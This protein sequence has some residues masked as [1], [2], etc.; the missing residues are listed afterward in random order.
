MISQ[1]RRTTALC[2]IIGVSFYST[3]AVGGGSFIANYGQPTP[4]RP[5]LAT[6]GCLRA[7]RI[8][9]L[10]R[11]CPC[12]RL[13][14]REAKDLPEL[15]NARRCSHRPVGESRRGLSALRMGNPQSRRRS[16]PLPKPKGNA[17]LAADLLEGEACAQ[18]AA[19]QATSGHHPLAG[20]PEAP[21]PGKLVGQRTESCGGRR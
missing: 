5:P 20:H 2:R 1:G 10:D 17:I 6:R 14:S 13:R 9:R 21:Q 12:R 19:R 18:W 7:R 4:A 15:S 3:M 8:G 11:G 16:A